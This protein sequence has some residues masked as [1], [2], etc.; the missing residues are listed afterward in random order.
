MIFC[1]LT[2]FLYMALAIPI[3]NSYYFT[4]F[5]EGILQHSKLDLS[6][7]IATGLGKPHM[8]LRNSFLKPYGGKS[9]HTTVEQFL[10]SD[11]WNKNTDVKITTE[12]GVAEK[13]EGKLSHWLW[14]GVALSSRWMTWNVIQ[15]KRHSTRN[16]VGECF[17][18]VLSRD[19]NFVNLQLTRSPDVATGSSPEPLRNRAQSRLHL[20][21]PKVISGHLSLRRTSEPLNV[22]SLYCFIFSQ[23]VRIVTDSFSRFHSCSLG[24]RE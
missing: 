6:I 24:W 20:L 19:Y 4:I 7:F 17:W 10:R 12:R 9:S 8:T 23:G 15:Q 5:W 16:W 1:M 11:I 14:S 18:K 3:V 22:L 21:K 13:R 2:D